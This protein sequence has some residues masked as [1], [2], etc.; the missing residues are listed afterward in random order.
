M[1]VAVAV[2]MVVFMRMVM[3][4]V[5]TVHGI[6]REVDLRLFKVDRSS[7][8]ASK[9]LVMANGSVRAHSHHMKNLC[10]ID[11]SRLGEIL[12][13]KHDLQVFLEIMTIKMID[14]ILL[15]MVCMCLI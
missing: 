7:A 4:V 1:A 13:R 8:V 11:F 3:M 5:E 9:M 2:D 14:D 15:A 6:G 12:V 10:W